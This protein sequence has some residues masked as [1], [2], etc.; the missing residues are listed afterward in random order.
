MRKRE[1]IHGEGW[2]VGGLAQ[3]LGTGI[4]LG[5][6]G[7]F[8]WIIDDGLARSIHG[9]GKR[10]AGLGITK[11]KTAPGAG[12]AEGAF[13]APEIAKAGT[14]PEM[15]W[16]AIFVCIRLRSNFHHTQRLGKLKEKNVVEPA[17][18]T[19]R[20]GWFLQLL[21]GSF[22]EAQGVLLYVNRAFHRTVYLCNCPGC[23]VSIGPWQFD[24]SYS[25]AVPVHPSYRVGESR[26]E[27]S[28]CHKRLTLQK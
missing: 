19:T 14:M 24:L 6:E 15:R 22:C 11:G 27:K 2:L 5:A 7:K 16:A 9:V 8:S 18:Q 13:V 26:I 28:T 25:P 17:R 4:G 12:R 20:L 21:Q 10:N 3:L 23:G 1:P